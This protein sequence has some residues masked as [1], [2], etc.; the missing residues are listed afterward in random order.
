M[1]ALAYLM[2]PQHNSGRQEIEM[3]EAA[4]RC[5]TMYLARADLQLHEISAEWGALQGNVFRSCSYYS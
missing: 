4:E 1:I 2:L 5:R 3:M